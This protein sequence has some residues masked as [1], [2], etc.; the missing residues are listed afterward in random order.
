MRHTRGSAHPTYSTTPPLNG[1]SHMHPFSAGAISTTCVRKQ[2]TCGP[3][4][5]LPV[6][7]RR[8]QNHGGE[9]TTSLSQEGT[10]QCTS[11]VHKKAHGIRGRGKGTAL[12]QHP[13]ETPAIAKHTANHWPSPF[14][15]H[16]DP[17]QIFPTRERKDSESSTSCHT[18]HPTLN[19]RSCMLP[20]S[21]HCHLRALTEEQQRQRPSPPLPTFA[22]Q[23]TPRRWR[24]HSLMLQQQGFYRKFYVLQNLKN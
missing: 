9:S 14:P 20:F 11:K 21:R 16:F 10:S 22:P 8:E 2:S 15:R 3:C 17:P 1:C 13:S 19:A 6:F 18:P 23:P 5:F 12:P 24:K 7:P 4:R